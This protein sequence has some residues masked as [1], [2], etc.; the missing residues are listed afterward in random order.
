MAQIVYYFFT[1]TVQ[2]G[3]AHTVKYTVLCTIRVTRRYLRGFI[4]APCK[5]VCRCDQLIVGH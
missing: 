3:V 5:W 4:L 2:I 1:L